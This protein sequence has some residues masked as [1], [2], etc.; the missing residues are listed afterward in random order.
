MRA[1]SASGEDGCF[2][3]MCEAGEDT[4]MFQVW[5]AW[6]LGVFGVPSSEIAP[7]FATRAPRLECRGGRQ[8][9]LHHEARAG[10]DVGAVR[11]EATQCPRR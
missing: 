5:G 8:E 2:S 6:D 11:G 7:G 1:G 3:G 10:G 9:C 4:P